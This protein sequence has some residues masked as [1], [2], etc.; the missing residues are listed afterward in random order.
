MRGKQVTS[1]IDRLGI[2]EIGL[3]LRSEIRKA[4]PGVDA[5]CHAAGDRCECALCLADA[6]G[7]A[8]RNGESWESRFRQLC[9]AVGNAYLNTGDRDSVVTIADELET[10][11]LSAKGTGE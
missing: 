8:A 4:I 6:L 9:G 2:V 7:R 3:R 10:Q 1:T 5:K 11:S